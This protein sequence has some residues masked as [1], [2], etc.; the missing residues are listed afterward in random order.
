VLKGT[1]GYVLAR[2]GARE[3][4]LRILNTI[5]QREGSAW[6]DQLNLSQLYLGLGDTARALDAMHLGLDRGEPIAAFHPLSAPM[7]DPVRASSRF[8]TLLR[9]VGLDPAVLAAPRGGRVP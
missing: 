1:F 6:L 5:V 3:D 7:Y 4:A 9:R 8:A 2:T